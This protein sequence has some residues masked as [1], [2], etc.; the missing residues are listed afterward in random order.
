M[1]KAVNIF[2]FPLVNAIVF[3]LFDFRIGAG[4]TTLFNG[5]VLCRLKVKM[6]QNVPF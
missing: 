4:G 2:A 6:C 5:A 1:R 3:Q